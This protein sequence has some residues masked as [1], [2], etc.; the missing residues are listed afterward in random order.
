MYNIEIRFAL[1]ENATGFA[2]LDVYIWTTG[3]AHSPPCF[4]S[5]RGH[6][7]SCSSVLQKIGSPHQ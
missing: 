2:R 3:M 5:H 6:G 1:L 7:P 4:L